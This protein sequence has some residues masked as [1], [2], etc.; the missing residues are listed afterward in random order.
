M[1]EVLTKKLTTPPVVRAYLDEVAAEQELS[2]EQLAGMER[3]LNLSYYY[4]GLD[5]IC[6]GK[7]DDFEV[8]FAGTEQETAS[9]LDAASDEIFHTTYLDRP[10]TWKTAKRDWGIRG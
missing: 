5:I 10:Y 7:G 6:R 4:G 8:L 3:T 9:W 1:P 2:P